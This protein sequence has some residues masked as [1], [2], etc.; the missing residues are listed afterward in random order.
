MTKKP[1]FSI[2]IPALN[3]EKY[4]PKLLEDLS[5]QTFQDFEV[6]VVDGKSEDKTVELSK[7]FT[8]K[9]PSLTIL[10][11]SIRNVSV[12]RNLGGTKA[13]SKYL[14]F[15]DADNRLPNYF[16]EGI[17][18]QLRIHPVDLFTC[19]TSP[20]TSTK[21]D[22]TIS[23]ANN[24]LIEASLIANNPIA[25]GAMIGCIRKAFL[26]EKGFDKTVGYGE[27]ADF[28]KRCINGGYVYKIFKEPKYTYSLRRFHSHG[29][30][31]T[32]QKVS[33]LAIKYLTGQ[34]V[35]QAIEYPMGG[36]HLNIKENNPDFIQAVQ[37]KFDEWKNNKKIHKIINSLLDQEE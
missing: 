15:N 18:F 32:I 30:I 6:I 8:P 23:T 1:F 3:E 13:K 25:P 12:Q 22:K 10:T 2:I 24:M 19:W 28:V 14:I 21:Q 17:R 34:K 33:V 16:L 29:A 5:K 4:L 31:K 26:T 9:L 20:E 36:K 37:E 11:S 27:D 7:M 35:D